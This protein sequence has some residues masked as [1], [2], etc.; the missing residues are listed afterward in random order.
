MPV[1]LLNEI[2][3]FLVG[4]II[5]YKTGR[6]SEKLSSLINKFMKPKEV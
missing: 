4:A 6:K 2:V 3:L 5:G 1:A